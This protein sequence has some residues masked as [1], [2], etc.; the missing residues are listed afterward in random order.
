MADKFLAVILNLGT[1][2]LLSAHGLPIPSRWH[3][4]SFFVLAKYSHIEKIFTFKGGWRRD[5]N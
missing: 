2:S 1:A 5:E 4:R 3:P